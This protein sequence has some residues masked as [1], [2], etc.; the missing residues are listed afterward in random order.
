MS[1]GRRRPDTAVD[2]VR[3]L[4]LAV[5]ELVVRVDLPVE[6]RRVELRGAIGICRENLPLRYACHRSM[7]ADFA[8]CVAVGR[9]KLVRTPPAYHP[10]MLLS[11]VLR[12]ELRRRQA[13]NRRY[14]LRAFA[15]DVGV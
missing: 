3:C 1:F 9:V 6:E 11:V 13:R 4:E 5:S 10:A 8:E 12:D 7:M 15:R 14:S 2:S